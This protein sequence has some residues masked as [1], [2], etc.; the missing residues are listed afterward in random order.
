DGWLGIFFAPEHAST[1]LDH[2][3]AGAERAG[4]KP[5]DLDIV[6]NVPVVVGDDLDACAEP[7]RGYTALYVGGMGSRKHN[8]YNRLARRMGYEEAA[9]RIQ[10]L[11]LDKR[12]REAMAA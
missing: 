4:K 8:F 3:R 9:E 11:Y 1:S 6:A 7:L 12:H 5:A 10:T 2:L